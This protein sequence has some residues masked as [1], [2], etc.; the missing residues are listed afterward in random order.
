LCDLADMC[1]RLGLDAVEP[2]S[3]YFLKS[4]D[5]FVYQLKHHIFKLGLEVS[6]VPIRNNFCLPPGKKLD[7]EMAHVRKWV[8]ICAKLGSPTMRIFAGRPP[9]G[10]GRMSREQ[11]FKHLID[12]IK[13]AC[14]YASTKGIFLGIE[15]HGYLTETADE[16]LKIYQAVDKPWF[17]IN[18]DTGNF[19]SEPY[20]SIAKCAPHAVVCQVKSQVGN[21]KTGKHEPAD[22]N[23]IIKILRDARYRGYVSLE[24]EGPD[25]HKNVPILIGKLQAVIKA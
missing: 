8:N 14:A 15:D 23:R 21:P 7:K 4:D 20:S 6:G 12:N 25:P 13:E 9:K 17:G 1:A 16:V 11:A 22:F 3:Y 5:D 10:K 2:T 19:R 18:L 24:Y